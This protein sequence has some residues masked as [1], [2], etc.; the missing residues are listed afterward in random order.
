MSDCLRCDGDVNVKLTSGE[1][2]KTCMKCHLK[3]WLG[4]DDV[5]NVVTNPPL[6]WKKFRGDCLVVFKEDFLG[7]GERYE[8]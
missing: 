5:F 4:S 2:I 7:Y 1:W 6:S 8:G 3:W